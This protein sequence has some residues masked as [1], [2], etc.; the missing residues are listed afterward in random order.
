MDLTLGKSRGELVYDYLCDFYLSCKIF[1]F[2]G[3]LCR[4]FFY[5]Q[6]RK[7]CLVPRFFSPESEPLF[8]AVRS[9]AT[10]VA[11]GKA[12]NAFELTINLVQTCNLACSYCFAGGGSY[13]SFRRAIS[14]EMLRETMGWGAS[15]FPQTTSIKLF[16]GEP[17]L[18]PDLVIYAI[19]LA[20]ES[21][22]KVPSIGA[23]TNLTV[24][25]DK[26]IPY[27]KKR[28]LRLTVSVDGSESIHDAQRFDKT[29]KGSFSRVSSNLRSLQFEG[30]D[31]ST[32][33]TYT[34][35]HLRRGLTPFEVFRYIDAEFSPYSIMMIPMTGARDW[36][37]SP[38]EFQELAFH[39]VVSL[40]ENCDTRAA[41]RLILDHLHIIFQRENRLTHC[42][43]MRS[44][45]SVS[46]DGQIWPCYRAIGSHEFHLGSVL[47]GEPFQT[48]TAQAQHSVES[49][50]R[51]D[52][53]ECLACP[54]RSI[55]RSCVG[56]LLEGEESMNPYM[57][58][59]RVGV[60]EGILSGV[61]GKRGSIYFRSVGLAPK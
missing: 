32:E 49:V 31:F 28:Q 59:W 34:P 57:C 2:S 22:S 36:P 11:C 55:C 14:K 7:E 24:L 54:V 15:C 13:S 56:E 52:R 46:A 3:A 45:I 17:L 60:I 18:R 61:V 6:S 26:L 20:E 33:C 8:N 44:T 29:G 47:D 12:A 4:I 5:K 10:S 30:I 53:P 42:E 58:A 40:I 38:N 23:V 21:F 25:S 35:E 37:L 51:N 27:L 19:Q 43:L 9:H 16:G 1:E 41:K 39:F 48:A 50:I